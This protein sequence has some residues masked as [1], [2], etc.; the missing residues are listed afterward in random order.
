MCA[1]PRYI[2]CRGE[3]IPASGG[4]VT[5]CPFRTYR[6]II[7]DDSR[8]YFRHETRFSED[9]NNETFDTIYTKPQINKYCSVKLLQQCR[10][11]SRR[12]QMFHNVH[13]VDR[14]VHD[15][16]AGCCPDIS[17]LS[18]RSS[19]LRTRSICPRFILMT[20]YLVK[21]QELDDT[22]RNRRQPKQSTD[23]KCETTQNTLQ[24]A[25]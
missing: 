20:K 2:Q 7:I 3:G 8:D 25:S 23:T 11:N 21:S 19:L 18:L 10:N 9:Q 14:S 6:T 22:A 24:T 4:A 16:V 12:K 1:G 13:S 17:P 15:P 5:G